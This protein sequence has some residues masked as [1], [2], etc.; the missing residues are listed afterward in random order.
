MYVMHADTND[1]VLLWLNALLL[2]LI[3]QGFGKLALKYKLATRIVF[4]CA[5]ETLQEQQRNTDMNH[6][7][8]DLQNARAGDLQGSPALFEMCR[9]ASAPEGKYRQ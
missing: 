2:C 4:I 3:L 9:P 1:G 6:H 7:A 5:S 8:S